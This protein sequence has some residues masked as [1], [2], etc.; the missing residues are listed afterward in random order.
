MI[1]IVLAIKYFTDC[2]IFHRH[3]DEYITEVLSLDPC[4]FLQKNAN[5]DT[6][7]VSL[8]PCLISQNFSRKILL[9]V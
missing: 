2:I 4:F 1:P 9:V 5:S 6:L 8:Y 7:W 3:N